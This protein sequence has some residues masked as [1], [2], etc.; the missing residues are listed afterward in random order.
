[1]TPTHVVLRPVEAGGKRVPGEMVDA[2]T[3]CHVE[4][5]VESRRLRPVMA[6]EE[7]VE[8]DCGRLFASVDQAADHCG[9]PV[10]IEVSPPPAATATPATRPP[11]FPGGKPRR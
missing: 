6:G 4:F 3:W 11:A 1:M 5:F 2:R 8:C 7:G 9:P 10:A